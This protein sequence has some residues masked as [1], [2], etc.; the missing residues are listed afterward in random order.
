MHNGRTANAQHPACGRESMGGTSIRTSSSHVLDAAPAAPWHHRHTHGHGHGC[1]HGHDCAHDDEL[2]QTEGH[3]LTGLSSAY[4]S[5]ASS[6]TSIGGGQAQHPLSTPPSHLHVCTTRHA[7]PISTDGTS[8]GDVIDT[9]PHVVQRDNPYLGAALSSLAHSSHSLAPHT[10]SE[11]A[12]T[13]PA[14]TSTAATATP[15]SPH[16]A[17]YQQRQFWFPMPD[18]HHIHAEGAVVQPPDNHMQ[19]HMQHNELWHSH[20]DHPRYSAYTGHAHSAAPASATVGGHQ[21]HTSLAGAVLPK[22]E[23]HACEGGDGG[24]SSS[25]ADTPLASPT[26]KKR[27]SRKCNSTTGRGRRRQRGGKGREEEEG[28]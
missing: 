20:V 14:P 8:W 18:D 17:P 3:S 6:N 24:A 13:P 12:P 19:H 22:V 2:W 1:D 4:H 25:S 27:K 10:G 11:S 28:V 7:A 21:L 16:Y 23:L 26:V 9:E 5:H 15:T